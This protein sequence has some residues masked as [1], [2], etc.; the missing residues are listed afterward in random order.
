[1]QVAR[2]ST[3]ADYVAILRDN[4]AEAQALFADL[5]IS[6]TTFFR[7]AGAFDKLAKTV[8]PNL[9]EDKGAADSIRV[10]IPGCATGEE[11]YSIA[12]LLLEEA[13]R[14]D[15]RCEIQV[16][17]SDLDEA[18]LTIGRD[19]R[20]PLAIEADLTDDRLRRFFTRESDHYR[21]TRELRDVVLFARHSLLKDP[22]FS[23]ADLIS[24]RNVLIY[25]DRKLQQQVCSTFH[26][27]LKPQGY[28]FLGSSESAD[29]PAGMFRPIDRE[30]R[31]YQ[32]MPVPNE[33]RMTAAIRA[34]QFRGRAP[35]CEGG[36]ADPGRR[37]GGGPSRGPRTIR[38]A[39]HR[40]RRFLPRRPPVGPGR[41]LPAALGR[42]A[43]QRHHRAGARRTAVRPA[44]RPAPRLF[45]QRGE[46]QRPDRRALQRRRATSL[47]PGEAAR[48]R[49]QRGPVGD[50][51]LLRG[52][53]AR[54]SA[55]RRPAPSRSTRRS[56]RSCSFSASCSSPSRSSGPR[57][58]NTRAPTRSCARPTRSCSRSTRSIVR[59]RR[60]SR[61]ARRSCS[62]STRNCRRSTAS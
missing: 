10:W 60:S 21:V 25:L 43:G 15:I 46:P 32:R 53:V 26:F 9:F 40:G 23:R 52:R 2:A 55:E 28:L 22:P 56:S 7:D 5:L 62:R 11:A 4:A 27:A 48:G 18:A 20:Y 41:A 38:P 13:S 3:M 61:P 19:G 31:I 58:K 16:F 42:D 1:M 59:P 50:R 47:S 37:R 30:A 6:V 36:R 14:H 12:I 51:V 35:G 57:A 29:A 44:R 34:A 54:R 45:P 49:T 17:A 24:C 39:E 33:V 8:I